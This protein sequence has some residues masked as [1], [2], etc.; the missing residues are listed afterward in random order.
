[1]AD[2]STFARLLTDRGF[3]ALR[4][5]GSGDISDN[6]PRPTSVSVPIRKSAEIHQF[7][8][9]GSLLRRVFRYGLP[10]IRR[11]LSEKELA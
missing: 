2:L 9:D 5:E 4:S 10:Q 7:L 6:K 1:M 3:G 8:I 11:A